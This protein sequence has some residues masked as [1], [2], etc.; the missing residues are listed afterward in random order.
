MLFH[1]VPQYSQCWFFLLASKRVNVVPVGPF[2]GFKWE[3]TKQK[4]VGRIVSERKLGNWIKSNENSPRVLISSLCHC[5]KETCI[6]W[7]HKLKR[8]NF[9][10]VRFKPKCVRIADILLFGVFGWCWWQANRL[11]N[12]FSA[13]LAIF[14]ISIGFTNDMI[15][16]KG[17]YSSLRLKKNKVDRW[18]V[19]WNC[20]KYYRVLCSLKLRW[21][22]MLNQHRC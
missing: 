11:S 19:L 20:V 10:D 8:I 7:R 2:T 16:L 1:Y 21:C 13:I 22:Q 15:T 14:T 4:E 5:F 3:S 12:L 9:S 18:K 17:S 6:F